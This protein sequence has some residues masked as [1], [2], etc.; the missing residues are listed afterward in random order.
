MVQVKLLGPEHLRTLWTRHEIA[1]MRAAQGD[2]AGA[3]SEFRDVLAG[4]MQRLPEH[5]DTLDTRLELARVM[6]AKGDLERARAE[7]QDVLTAKIRVF[8][9]DHPSTALTAREIDSL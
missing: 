1:R 9:P 4:R 8:G 7:F 5:P 2:Y 3:E 6:A